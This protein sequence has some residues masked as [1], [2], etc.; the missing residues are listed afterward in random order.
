MGEGDKFSYVSLCST[1]TSTCCE[2]VDAPPVF[3]N[4]IKKLKQIGKDTSEYLNYLDLGEG[5]VWTSIKKQKDSNFCKFYDQEKKLCTIYEHRP[6][7]CKMYPF[8]IGFIDK[9]PWWYVYSC[10]PNSDWSWTEKHLQKFEA[11]PYFFEII[12]SLKNYELY[13][14]NGHADYSKPE[15]PIRK[16]KWK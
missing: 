7:D 16:V 6:L 11:D 10:N 14:N 8:D 12:D 3:P 4:D 2:S 1:C 9:E 13:I 5:R 15:V